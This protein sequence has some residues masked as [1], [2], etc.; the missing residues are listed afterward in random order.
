MKESLWMGCGRQE[1]IERERRRRRQFFGTFDSRYFIRTYSND[2]IVERELKPF[3]FSKDK[4]VRLLE[5]SKGG[6]LDRILSRAP[7]L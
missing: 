2:G 7:N 5:L 4:K 6:A 1:I 3:I